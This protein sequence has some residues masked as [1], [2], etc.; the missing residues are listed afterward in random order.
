MSE[1]FSTHSSIARQRRVP[2]TAVVLLVF[3]SLRPVLA[4]HGS[5]KE[6]ALQDG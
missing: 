3:L 6:T 1:I 5:K 2:S 4:D